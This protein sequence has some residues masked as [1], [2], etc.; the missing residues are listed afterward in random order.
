MQQLPKMQSLLA[1]KHA[2]RSQ[3]FQKL[4]GPQKYYSSYICE[5][6]SFSLTSS[7][8]V[9]SFTAVHISGTPLS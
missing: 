5:D 7:V 9:V 1:S 6:N 3:S 4:R 2:K 8:V